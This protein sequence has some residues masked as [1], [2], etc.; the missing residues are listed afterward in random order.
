MRLLWL[1]LWYPRP[2]APHANVWARELAKAAATR[3][4]VV[5]LHAREGREADVLSYEPFPTLRLSHRQPRFFWVIPYLAAVLRGGE[6]IRGLGAFRLIHAHCTF[7]AGLGGLL[8]S[9]RHRVPLVVTEHWGPFDQLMGFS[10][11]SAQAIRL[12]LRRAASVSAVSSSLRGEITR[13]VPRSDIEVIPPTVDLDVFHAGERAPATTRRVRLLFAGDLSH[14]RKRLEDVLEALRILQGDGGRSWELV[15]V[16][17]GEL[18]PDYEAQA[19][20]LGIGE[21]VRFWGSLPLE[22][23]AEAMRGCDIFVMPSTYETFGAVYAEALA[24]GKPV[25]AGR[26]GGPEDFVTPEVGRLVPPRDVPALAEAIREVA[27]ALPRFEPERL[28]AYA[29]ERFSLDAVGARYD[30]VYRRVCR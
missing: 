17:D 28:R 10:A 16:G 21:Q 8:L 9:F 13:W 3:H 30:A 19:R 15:V 2:D 1:P 14:A 5:V 20:C 6:R 27:A 29:A 26:C 22:G 18:R 24:C 11:L 23:V 25:I 4:D 7:P 12:V